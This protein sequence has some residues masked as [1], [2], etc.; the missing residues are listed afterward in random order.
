MNEEI[1]CKRKS[2]WISF[3]NLASSAAIPS[4]LIDEIAGRFFCGEL[5]VAILNGIRFFKGFGLGMFRMFATMWDL[6]GILSDL[7]ESNRA[8]IFFVCQEITTKPRWRMN[9]KNSTTGCVRN[10]VTSSSCSFQFF[11]KKT[12]PQICGPVLK[13]PKISLEI[14]S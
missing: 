14:F 12:G 8:R 2:F 4:K 5:V 10:C 7:V 6:S 3:G 9:G 1:K 13:L 11:N